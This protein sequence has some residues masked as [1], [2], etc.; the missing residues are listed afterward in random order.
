[1]NKQCTQCKRNLGII[2]NKT[3]FCK[4]CG[5]L[6][7]ESLFTDKNEIYKISIDQIALIEMASEKMSIDIGLETDKHNKV[8]AIHYPDLNFILGKILK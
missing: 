8:V 1:M 5:T 4:I 7:T 2:G 6:L 3:S